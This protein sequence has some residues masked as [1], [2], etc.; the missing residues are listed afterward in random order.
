MSPQLRSAA[1]LFLLMVLP[2]TNSHAGDVPPE[3]QNVLIC[4]LTTY[5]THL[6]NTKTPALYGHR[7]RNNDF[8]VNSADRVDD[9]GAEIPIKKYRIVGYQRIR[10]YLGVTTDQRYKAIADFKA[11][12]RF[13]EYFICLRGNLID[14]EYN[15]SIRTYIVPTAFRVY[16]KK[17]SF[18]NPSELDGQY[19][20]VE[21]KLVDV[22]VH[23]ADENLIDGLRFGFPSIIRQIEDRFRK[24]CHLATYASFA[25]ER[26]TRSTL[27][28]TGTANCMQSPKPDVLSLSFEFKR[29]GENVIRLTATA[30]Q[31]ATQEHFSLSFDKTK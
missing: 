31:E 18:L 6:G 15:G 19:K 24:N 7:D 25:V 22:D 13:E 10:R 1:F 26:K 11:A 4:G 9:E 8:A 17:E 27:V 21:G 16:D 3:N 28:A 5:Y 30:T 2:T 20:D 23:V 29:T 14:R 12:T